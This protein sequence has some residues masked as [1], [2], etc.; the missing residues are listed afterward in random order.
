M[1]TR[2]PCPRYRQEQ[3]IRIHQRDLEKAQDMEFW[4]ISH[5]QDHNPFMDSYKTGRQKEGYRI[6]SWRGK[7]IPPKKP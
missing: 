6:P 7:L 4:I 5:H 1:H 3:G 2:L